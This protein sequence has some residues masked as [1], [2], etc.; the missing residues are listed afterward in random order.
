M[1]GIELVSA[2]ALLLRA[3]LRGA[4]ERLLEGGLERAL[5]FDL[6][7]DVADDATEPCAQQ[8]QLPPMALE[9]LGVGIAS[10]HHRS[11]FGDAQIRLPQLKA[12][13][14]GQPIEPLDRRMDQLGIGREGDC[15]GLDGAVHRHSLEI[16]RSRGARFGP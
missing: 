14:A 15:L 13:R 7:A 12:V 11:A 3:D 2:L 4:R 10:R 9:L 6:A 8:P 16:A 1:E 5:A